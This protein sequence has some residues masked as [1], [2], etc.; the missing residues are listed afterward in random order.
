MYTHLWF[1]ANFSLILILVFLVC[2][3]EFKSLD[4]HNKYLYFKLIYKSLSSLEEEL[5]KQLLNSRSHI[6]AD[7][8]ERHKHCNILKMHFFLICTCIHL[9]EEEVTK[10]PSGSSKSS[11]EGKKKNITESWD[12]EKQQAISLILQTLTLPLHHLVSSPIME[13]EISGCALRCC[14]IVLENPS[15]TRDKSLTDKIFIIVG[16]SVEKYRQSLGKL[17]FRLT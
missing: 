2:L 13:E 8:I 7:A 16:N 6:I 15:T 14:W 4:H 10:K 12:K 5:S 11:E 1:N 9:F 3:R 17:F